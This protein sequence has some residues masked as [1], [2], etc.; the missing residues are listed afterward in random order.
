MA[1]NILSQDEVDALLE[2]VQ[3]DEGTDGSSQE[4]E[5]A[6]VGSGQQ[7]DGLEE[8]GRSISSR[9]VFPMVRL[10]TLTPDMESALTFVHD[11]FAY[12]AG[13]TVSVA[14]RAQTH[15]KLE[16][17]DQVSYDE[18][19]RGLPEPSSLWALRLESRDDHIVLC[20]ESLL[21]HS[22]VDFLM[23]GEGLLPGEQLGISELDHSVIESIVE[24]L[25]A[26]LKKAWGRMLDFNLSIDSNETRPG[27]L[28]IYSPSELVT[29]ICM[30][31]AIGENEGKLFLGIPGRVTNEAGTRLN[32]ESQ[33]QTQQRVEDGVKKI[34]QMMLSL[35]TS[36]EASLVSTDIPFAELLKI[37]EGDVV[38]LDHSID[39]PVLVTVNGHQKFSATVVVS[40]QKR[41]I[42]IK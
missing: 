2:T 40:Q 41:G 32:H 9:K 21:A 42:E 31:M 25:C 27:L 38:R 5:R 24:S 39:D 7:A 14:L 6:D 11:S 16:R 15:L 35:P 12:N 10:Q 17:I 30:V 18:F 28:Q 22:M 20:M 3:E 13:S 26:E 19:I 29:L 37:Q 34:K 33:V 36:L 23:G 1:E 8:T 4:G